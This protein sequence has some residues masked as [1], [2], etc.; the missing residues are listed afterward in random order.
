MGI[1]NKIRRLIAIKLFHKFFF[2]DLSEAIFSF[3]FDDVPNSAFTNGAS[4]LKKYG[5]TG[6]YYVSLAFFEKNG[7]DGVYSDPKHLF[8]VIQDNGE[9][10]CHSFSHIHLYSSTRNQIIADLERNQK[11]IN[12]LIPNYKFTNFSYP[13]GEQ[14]LP[15]KRFIMDKY[16]SA[17][18]VKMGINYNPVD[19]SNLKILPLEEGIK[20]E[21]IFLMIDKAVEE[22]G[23]LIFCAHDVQKN[24]SEFGCSISYFESV[25]KYCFKKKLEVQTIRK[26]L[27]TI[28][29]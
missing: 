14:T 26:V 25:V 16:K 3:T 20:L 28:P 10:A 4:I 27:E 8:E 24:P 15:V 11:K 29:D 6:T 17:R 13:Y 9:L 23:W 7:I 22:R 19:L 2:L 21:N 1:Y 18:G 12:E 5:Y